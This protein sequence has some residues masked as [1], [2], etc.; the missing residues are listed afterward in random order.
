M[1]GVA[2]AINPF[3]PQEDEVQ[4]S[5]YRINKYLNILN[6]AIKNYTN[7]C[8]KVSQQGLISHEEFLLRHEKLMAKVHEE[9]S[10]TMKATLIF[11]ENAKLWKLLPEEDEKL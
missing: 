4:D 9:K 11:M 1:I 8:A 7:L 10:P 2:N 5:Q 6:L 3:P